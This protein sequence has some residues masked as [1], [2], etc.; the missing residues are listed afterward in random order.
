MSTIYENLLKYFED[1]STAQIKTDWEKT[2]K[3]NQIDSPYVDEFLRNTYHCNSVYNDIA[4][5]AL[6]PDIKINLLT[7][8]ENPK[9][10]SGFSF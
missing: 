3:Y 5:V 10:T 9:F 8:F 2:E 4:N 1:T 6:P 7:T